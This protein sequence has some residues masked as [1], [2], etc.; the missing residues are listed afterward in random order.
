MVIEQAGYGVVWRGQKSWNGVAILARDCEPIVTSMELRGTATTGCNLHPLISD[1]SP[2]DP[3]VAKAVLS[4]A[5]AA[6]AEIDYFR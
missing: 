1:L 6:T 5:R 3:S 2:C 4:T